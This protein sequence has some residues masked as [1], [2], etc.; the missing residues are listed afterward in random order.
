MK[1]YHFTIMSI[2]PEENIEDQHQKYGIVAQGKDQKE[3]EAEAKAKFGERG[4]PI[5][6]IKCNGEV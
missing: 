6:W 5:F 4:L 2:D 3:A 1:K